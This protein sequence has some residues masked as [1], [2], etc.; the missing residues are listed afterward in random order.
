MN[1]FE[2]HL[3]WTLVVGLVSTYIVVL[4]LGIF[5]ANADPDHENDV[6]GA[7]VLIIL[8]FGPLIECAW[9]LRKKRQHLIWLLVCWLLFVGW[10]IP[11][12][13]PKRTLDSKLSVK[14]NIETTGNFVAGQSFWFA[15]RGTWPYARITVNEDGMSIRLQYM[16]PFLVGFGNM[17][18]E[19]DMRRIDL[20][21]E[22]IQGYKKPFVH[23]I[24]WFWKHIRLFHTE[25]TYPPYILI[26]VNR[27]KARAIC[28]LLRS[29]GVEE[30]R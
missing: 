28:D 12:L 24:S 29:H 6:L 22:H 16:G 26:G 21:Y 7:T 20:P 14:V 30:L 1:W 23:N 27:W 11:V 19:T 4:T 25:G 8:V 18:F 3:N 5:G 9:V 13:L 17:L 10:L 2:K 15:L